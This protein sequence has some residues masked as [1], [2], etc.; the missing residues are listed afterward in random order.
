MVSFEFLRKAKW[1]LSVWS[2]LELYHAKTLQEAELLELQ[3]QYFIQEKKITKCSQNILLLHH[4]I[5][6]LL[7]NNHHTNLDFGSFTVTKMAAPM[8]EEHIWAYKSINSNSILRKMKCFL[9][10]SP[11]V[12]GVFL[13]GCDYKKFYQLCFHKSLKRDI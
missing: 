5:D 13:Q 2:F 12:C 4:F 3:L 6:V 9:N 10:E 11:G 7:S 8:Q 1:G